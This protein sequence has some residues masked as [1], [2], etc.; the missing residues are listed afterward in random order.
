MKFEEVL[1]QLREGAVIRRACWPEGSALAMRRVQHSITPRIAAFEAGRG[2][3]EVPAY[4]ASLSFDE[5][6]T[7]DWETVDV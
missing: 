2:T 7:E 1:T 5:L 6:L 4:L 3:G